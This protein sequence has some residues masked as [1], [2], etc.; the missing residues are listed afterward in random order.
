MDRELATLASV[1]ATALIGAMATDGWNRTRQALVDLWHA[2]RPQQRDDALAAALEETRAELMEARQRADLAAQDEILARCQRFLGE[3]L[4]ADAGTAER[5]SAVLGL[6]AHGAAGRG[7]GEVRFGSATHY[8][9][10]DINQVGRDLSIH[11]GRRS[12]PLPPPAD[13][14]PGEDPD[15]G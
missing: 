5:L 7:A 2:V 11:Q 3:L 14:T 4:A 12:A 1:A 10:G 6:E 15:R 8:G 9:S 13:A